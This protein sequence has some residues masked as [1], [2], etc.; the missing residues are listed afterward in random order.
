M[1]QRVGAGLTVA[2]LLGFAFGAHAQDRGDSAPEVLT[3][4]RAVALALAEN[5]LVANA[6]L[7]V[8]NSREQLAAFLT[9]RLPKLDFTF[10]GSQLLTPV[11]FRFAE[12]TFGTFPATGPIPAAET[13]IRTPLR[14][15]ALLLASVTQPLSQLYRIGLGARLN[16]LSV[17]LAEEKLRRQKH[18]VAQE[19]KQAYFAIVQTESALSAAGEAIRLHRELDR[20]ITENLAQQA[21][22][23]A[24]SLEVKA[25]LAEA[26][27]AALQLR[28]A[29]A[30][31][32]EQL[33]LLLGRDIRT[34]F[35]VQ[36]LPEATLAE[37]DLASAQA[38]ALEQRPE[39]R[40]ARLS[41]QQAEFDRRL[42]KN[43]YVP[44]VSLRLSYLSPFGIEFLPRNITTLGLYVTWEPFDWGRKRHELAAQSRTVRQAT[45]GTREIESQILVE[46]NAR[47]RRLEDRRAL[48]EVRH[49]RQDAARE[50]LRVATHQYAQKAVELK[51]VLSA[52]TTLAQADAEY[53][54]ALSE[55]WTARADFEK[56][57]GEE[58]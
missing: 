19:V 9:R 51:D 36:A 23:K 55:F 6:A 7:E 48:V 16:E 2:A 5:R 28:Q 49:Q 12:G 44:E 11:E 45:L 3:L 37:L 15:N 42:K 50:R 26:D 53:Q 14:P 41:V 21:V 38:R 24:D 18:S 52:Q 54:Q 33:N 34:E 20:T 35:S 58:P 4:E 40:E 1:I 56:A 31:Q 25:R 22:L 17:T 57:L 39:I 8:E 46:V 27:Y 10:F 32:K 30:T 47:F 29:L 13:R 43:E